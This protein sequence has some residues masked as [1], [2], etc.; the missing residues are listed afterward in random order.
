MLYVPEYTSNNCAYI[1]N[2]D[3][4]RVYNTRPNSPGTYSYIDYYPHLHY[5]YNI[6][7]TTFSNYS[8]YPTCVN[9]VSTNFYNRVD[10]TEILIIFTIFVGFSYI[11]ISKLVKT[12][13]RGGRIW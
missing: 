2:S 12:L 5:A 1:Y 7:S 13:L 4:I 6:G 3:I 10:I 8:T 9:D 11:L